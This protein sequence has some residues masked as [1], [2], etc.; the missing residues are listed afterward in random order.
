[1]TVPGLDLAALEAGTR[2]PG[3]SR[4]KTSHW[5][6]IGAVVAVLG[7]LA[8]AGGQLDLTGRA[9]VNG[10]GFA[11]LGRFFAA[12]VRPRTSPEILRAAF[13][14]TK[15]TLS[16]ALLGTIASVG[17]GLMF[18][19]VLCRA[20]TEGKHT[21]ISGA[22]RVLLAPIR[23]AH[24]VLWALLFASVLGI[25][26]LVAVL[27]I[28][29]PFG[30]VTARVFSEILDAQP[31]APYD[32]LRAGGARRFSAFV[33]GIVPGALNDGTSYTFYRFECAVRSAAVLGVVGAGGLGEQLRLSFLEADYRGMWSF[34]WCL[35]ALSAIVEFGSGRIRKR[36]VSVA[37]KRTFTRRTL[38]TL[39]LAGMAWWTLG[40][41][42]ATL[43]SA[44]TRRLAGETMSQWFPAD[45]SLDHRQI[46]V[47]LARETLAI[48][49]ASLFISLTLAVPLALLTTRSTDAGRIRLLA[50]SFGRFVLLITRALPPS[51][52]AYLAVLV[53][54]PGP[55]P[56]AVALGIYNAGVLG[57]LLGEVL[58][59]LDQRPRSALRASGASPAT[60]TILGILPTASPLFA[61]Y[62]LYRWEVAM[63]ETIMVGIV[64]AGGLGAHLNQR[65]AAFDWPEV[66]A[67]IAVLIGLTFLVDLTSTGFRRYL[68]RRS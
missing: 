66:T 58:E 45:F 5:Q 13:T 7:A 27:A 48:S 50:S 39:T 10:R 60:A 29:L 8:W 16:Y 41:D 6:R 25:N 28:A 15:V 11:E 21:A 40:V 53:L 51:V 2:A 33:L 20:R 32:A 62:G 35:I 61:G 31:T 37:Q 22:C 43:W 68:L 57:R 24:E 38:A 12:A 54:F 1:M 9:L 4:T 19:V 49:I 47:P 65:L 56:A 59:N 64:A 3:L 26:P 17:I 42:V 52:W 67:T 23:G 46:L 14:G 18:G 30:A 55:L 36:A 44:R 34:L 63:R